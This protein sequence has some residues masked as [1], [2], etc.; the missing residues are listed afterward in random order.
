MI[1][2][3]WV[4]YRCYILLT[5]SHTSHVIRDTYLMKLWFIMSD[6]FVSS[7]GGLCVSRLCGWR[8]IFSV[9][10][11]AAPHNPP[12]NFTPLTKEFL[13]FSHKGVNYCHLLHFPNFFNF[14]WILNCLFF[15]FLFLSQ[16][17]LL[18]CSRNDE[19]IDG[20]G[21]KLSGGWITVTSTSVIRTSQYCPARM[22]IKVL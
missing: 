7:R 15:F 10:V 14:L 3:S 8:S 18:K 21:L 1:E 20:I 9:Q 13:L 4:R 11:T 16:I 2:A 22:N 12:P 19:I 17:M 5:L 6:Y